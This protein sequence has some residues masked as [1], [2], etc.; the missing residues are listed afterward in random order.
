MQSCT[1]CIS[2]D[3]DFQQQGGTAIKKRIPAPIRLYAN[4]HCSNT[5]HG[6][7]DSL[8]ILFGKSLPLQ[9]TQN[10]M[11]S[12]SFPTPMVN[13]RDMMSE[14]NQEDGVVLVSRSHGA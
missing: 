2:R 11:V 1:S 7:P 4:Q 8:K 3:K 6:G 10:M 5:Q 14:D 13:P 12:S 9:Q